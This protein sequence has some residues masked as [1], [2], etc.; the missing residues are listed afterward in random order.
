MSL[1]IFSEC[2]KPIPLKFTQIHY[3]HQQT[4]Q[5]ILGDMAKMSLFFKINATWFD[6]LSSNKVIHAFF[7][8]CNS[9]C[10]YRNVLLAYMIHIWVPINLQYK[11][12]QYFAQSNFFCTNFMS[13]YI[14]FSWLEREHKTSPLLVLTERTD[15]QNL[16][17][18]IESTQARALNT[19]EDF[20]TAPLA[21]VWW[22][23]LHLTCMPL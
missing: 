10:T 19:L 2:N 14:F 20:W 21:P 9:K 16:T 8:F 11:F 22:I 15:R 13:L 7:F 3:Q 17:R 18:T 12:S 1:V 23:G 5:T 4:D 6:D